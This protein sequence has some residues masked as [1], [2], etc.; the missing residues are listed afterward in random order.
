MAHFCEHMT[1][2]GTARRSTMQVVNTLETVGG[3]LNA[4]T[5]KEDT[6]YHAAI[7]REHFSRA[8]DLLTDIV[9]CSLYPQAEIDK[10]VEVI[11]DE[12]ESY[13]DSPAELIY[14]DFENIIF[15]GHPL[16]HNILGEAARLRTYTTAHARRFTSRYYR[17]D[18]TVF[19]VDGNI[20]F[21]RLTVSLEKR[22]GNIMRV[23]G[24]ET[25]CYTA[26]SAEETRGAHPRVIERA[27]GTHQAH[28]MIGTE[29]YNANHPRRMALA[30]LNN[31]LAGPGM[32]ARLNVSL[33][34]RNG[35]V[36]TV[37]GLTTCYSDTGLW[38]LYFGCDPDNV[39]RCLKLIRRETDRLISRPLSDTALRAAKLQLKGQMAIA[40]DNREQFALDFSN[41]YLHEGTGTQLTDIY[42]RIEA[43]DAVTLQQ[44]AAELMVEDRLT[45][46]IYK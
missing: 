5:N 34:E 7:G 45:T 10:E 46:L 13:N 40:S 28:V 9:F 17:P 22:I 14:D 39:T 16:G 33:R 11:A 36:Y 20:D 26:S 2:K 44:V 38:S 4:F 1:F 43:I 12:I 32:N 15:N 24:A 31:I 27:K 21:R 35:L 30:L 42:E 6:V 8:V 25:V 29:T 18:N 3:D 41:R 19:F 37:E 23:R